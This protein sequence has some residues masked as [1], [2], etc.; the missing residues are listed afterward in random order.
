MRS[1]ITVHHFLPRY[2]GGAEQHAYRVAGELL[3]RGHEPWLVCIERIDQGPAGGLTWHD[4]VYEGLRV[5]RLSF[6]L[7][8]APDRQRWEYDNPWIGDHLRTLLSAFRADVLHVFSGY[9]MTGSALRVA[10]DLG[11]PTVLT[12]TD[13]WFLCPR[14]TMRRS[15]GTLSTLPID[16]VTCARCLGEERKRYRIPGRLAP[17]LMQAFWRLRRRPVEV[18]AQRQAYLRETMAHIGAVLAG[19]AFLCRSLIAAGIDASRITICRQGIDQPVAPPRDGAAP[20]PPTL[21]I[22]YVGQIAEHKGVHLLVE[23]VR[24]L[25]RASLTLHIYG[26]TSVFPAYSRRLRQ[27]A[28]ADP[29]IEFKGTYQGLDQRQTALHDCDVIVVPSLW[30]ENNPNAI[31]EALAHGIPVI[32]AN[33][34]SMPE[35]IEHERNGLLF[36]S[37][38]ATD[39]ARQLRRLLDEPE[40]QRTLRGNITPRRTVGQEVDDVEAAYRRV[41]MRRELA[42]S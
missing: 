31:N 22:G 14:I 33:L 34:G 11:I 8:A 42:H 1:V 7:R 29:R 39:L 21:R 26:D 3:R 4:D 32:T 17:R 35:A 2:Q 40:L 36:V 18:I 13:Y 23:A 24:Q 37:G 19:S 38:S 41:I 30:Y 25:G 15:D 10:H 28:G 9:L 27:L 12:A 6:N 20:R 16:P 5:R